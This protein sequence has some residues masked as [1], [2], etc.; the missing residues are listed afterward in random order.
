M[1]GGARDGGG[2]NSGAADGC[3]GGDASSEG[4]LSAGPESLREA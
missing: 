4:L 3:R 1:Q 2:V